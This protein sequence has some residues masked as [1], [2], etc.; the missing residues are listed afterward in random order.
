MENKELIQILKEEDLS[1]YRIIINNVENMTKEQLKDIILSLY[2]Q[3]PNYITS[4]I[5]QKHFYNDVIEDLEAT[6][7]EVEK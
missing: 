5:L 6:W 7:K 3:L 4:P 2:L 1:F